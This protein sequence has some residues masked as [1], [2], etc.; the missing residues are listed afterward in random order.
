[1]LFTFLR[2]PE[3]WEAGTQTGDKEGVN[4]QWPPRLLEQDDR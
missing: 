2:L 4:T 1:M 3:K